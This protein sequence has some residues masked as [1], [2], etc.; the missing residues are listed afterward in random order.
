VYLNIGH[1]SKKA[2]NINTNPRVQFVVD[3][4]PSFDD[5]R[6]V[7]ITGDSELISDGKY[8]EIG[9]ILLYSKYPKY[10]E[11]YPIEE[12][13]WSKY[14]LVITPSKISSWGPLSK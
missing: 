7:L 2:R 13:G 3:D 14:I 4:V 10:E 5:F 9:K 1:N 8:H 11:K 6:G 12:G